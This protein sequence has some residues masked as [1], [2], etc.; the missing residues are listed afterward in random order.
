MA[1]GRAK[2]KRLERRIAHELGGQRTGNTGTAAPDVVAGHGGWLVVECK[3][4]GSLPAWLLHAMGQA[5]AAAGPA[6]LPVAILHETGQPYAGALVVMRLAD[7]QSWFGELPQGP[8][9]QGAAK[10]G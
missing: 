7:F 3:E 9:G 1:T 6:Q 10:R 4:R 5:A 2:G 8:G